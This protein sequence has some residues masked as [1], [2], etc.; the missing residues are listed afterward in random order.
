MES[1]KSVIEIVKKASNQFEYDEHYYFTEV[2]IIDGKTN[3]GSTGDIWNATKFNP[4][5]PDIAKTWCSFIKSF[6]DKHYQVNVINISLNY[7]LTV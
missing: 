3:I 2:S 4:M 1:I 5:F 7:D 6:L